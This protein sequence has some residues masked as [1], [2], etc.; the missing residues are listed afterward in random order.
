MHRGRPMRES[1]DHRSPGWIRQSR[2]CCIQLIHNRMV[3]DCRLMSTANFAILDYC[4][5]TSLNL[6][7]GQTISTATS[8]QSPIRSSSI[9]NDPLGFKGTDSLRHGS[10]S[11]TVPHS[12]VRAAH[13]HVIETARTRVGTAEHSRLVRS[14]Q[15]R[16]RLR[17]LIPNSRGAI[18][19]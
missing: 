10:L 9:Q 7:L 18:S 12:P 8:A 6:T 14:M 2:E 3:V 4:S 17:K 13:A 1:L 11:A 19:Q 5:L 16:V 15:W